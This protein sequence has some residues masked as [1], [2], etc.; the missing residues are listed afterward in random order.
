MKTFEKLLEETLDK[1]PNKE[2]VLSQEGQ[3]KYP[4]RITKC[5]INGAVTMG[6]NPETGEPQ[7]FCLLIVGSQSKEYQIGCPGDGILYFPN[8]FSV[9]EY[10]IY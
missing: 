5:F 2:I 7:K 4:G 10:P 6:P 8:D 1:I 3:W 9:I